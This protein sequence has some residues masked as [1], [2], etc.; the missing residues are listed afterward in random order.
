MHSD[1]HPQDLEA[2]LRTQQHLLG[3]RDQELQES[4]QREQDLALDRDRLQGEVQ[5]LQGVI[6][7]LEEDN[8]ALRQQVY[9][10]K[11]ELQRAQSLVE[12]QVGDI[13]WGCWK[14]L[15]A[16]VG[17]VKAVQALGCCL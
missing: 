15:W 13:V 2:R 17:G 9:D 14:A 4:K 8:G 12:K 5:Q 1:V 6:S 16:G 10:L 7:E 11:Q 3:E